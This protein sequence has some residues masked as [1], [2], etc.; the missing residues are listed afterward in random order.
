M[1]EELRAEGQAKGLATWEIEHRGDEVSHLWLAEQLRAHR[2]DDA[3]LSEEG[4]DDLSRL[5]EQRVWIVDPLDG[6]SSFGM[7]TPEWAVHVAL[8][9]DGVATAGAVASPGVGV[10]ASTYVPSVADDL[11]RTSPIVVAGRTRAWSDGAWVAEAIRGEVVPCSSAGFKAALL[12]TGRADVYVHDS[13]LYEWDVCA[14]AVMASAFGLD[15]SD[16]HGGALEFNKTRP[17]VSGLVIC[18]QEFTESVLHS[19]EVRRSG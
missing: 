3:L 16:Q 1:L 2:P 15:V 10:T 13:P 7:G 5:A 6:S 11:Q 8:V 18:R 17:V 12:A 9:V 14:P 4:H 19:L